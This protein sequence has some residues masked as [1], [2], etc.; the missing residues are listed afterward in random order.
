MGAP[1]KADCCQPGA[2][3]HA[4]CDFV[5]SATPEDLGV[6][7]R[8]PV[9]IHLHTS[10]LLLC[11]GGGWTENPIGSI[12]SESSGINRTGK[13]L[14]ALVGLFALAFVVV[15]ILSGGWAVELFLTVAIIPILGLAGVAQFCRVRA[16]NR[17]RIW[18]DR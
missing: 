13:S 2:R 14:M 15:A 9:G 8:L 18:P 6:P 1:A 17:S 11:G 5:R 10:G 4:T 12:G 7:Q 3:V 16:Y